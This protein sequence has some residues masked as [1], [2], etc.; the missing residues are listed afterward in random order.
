M[1]RRK[2]AHSLKGRSI[3]EALADAL[4]EVRGHPVYE[5]DIWENRAPCFKLLDCAKWGWYGGGRHKDICSWDNM[6]DCL[7]YGFDFLEDGEQVCSRSTDREERA[8]EERDGS[9]D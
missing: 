5:D 2:W 8:K 1:K 4:S 9:H 6:K 3:K 7:K